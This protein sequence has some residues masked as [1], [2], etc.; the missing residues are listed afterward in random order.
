MTPTSMLQFCLLYRTK[1]LP[2]RKARRYSFYSPLV[3]FFDQ[4]DKKL[5]LFQPLSA[6]ILRFSPLFNIFE[7]TI[8][9]SENKLSWTC[10]NFKSILFHWN[11]TSKNK[12][13]AQ[14]RPLLYIYS[15][16]FYVAINYLI[17]VVHI[18]TMH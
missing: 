13:L 3:S 11:D 12:Y 17:S 14:K 9:I 4:L 15:T 6:L 5:N 1:S 10:F 18:S 16:R 8:L 7:S 2:R